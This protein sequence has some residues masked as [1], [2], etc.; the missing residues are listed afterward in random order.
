[1]SETE[2]SFLIGKCEGLVK[3]RDIIWDKVDS[4]LK[5]HFVD[6]GIAKIDRVFGT[7]HARNTVKV[8]ARYWE[9]IDEIDCVIN[10]LAFE[11]DSDEG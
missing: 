5:G 6:K 11:E 4:T 3:A 8:L 9:L 2:K 7:T 10:E 1:M